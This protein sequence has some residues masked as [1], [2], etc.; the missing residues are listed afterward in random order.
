MHT[1][2][3][4][5]EECAST[6]S[7]TFLIED[8]EDALTDLGFLDIDI[9]VV[10]RNSSEIAI[11][12]SEYRSQPTASSLLIFHAL[13]E[14]QEKQHG[15]LGIQSVPL[16]SSPPSLLFSSVE[17]GNSYSFLSCGGHSCKLTNEVIMGAVWP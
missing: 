7:G 4:P 9:L 17:F 11:E 10:A 1:H 15:V 6:T 13:Q 8:D 2:E 14:S 5:K 3:I 12:Y 16:I